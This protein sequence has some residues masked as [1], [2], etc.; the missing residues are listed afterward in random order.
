M[1]EPIIRT[2]G[3]EDAESILKLYAYYIENTAITFEYKVPSLPEFQARIKNTLARYPYLVLEQD[4]RI[5]GYCYA[6]RL[7][8][9]A[10]YDWSCEVSIYIA[11]TAQR[12]GFGRMLYEALEEKLKRMGVTNLY[13]CIAYPIEEDE[14]LS[15]NSAQFHAH[16]GFEKVGE[17]HQCGCKFD[18]WYN[19]IWMEKLIGEHGSRQPPVRA[20]G[21][22]E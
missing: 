10:A 1:S 22:L 11:H 3:P 14:Y 12:C 5:L 16:L 13:A 4:G 15:K 2:A 8:E 19:M 21:A 9:R 18:R 6:G 17:F 7:K 20:A